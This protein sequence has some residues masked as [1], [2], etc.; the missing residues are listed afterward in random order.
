MKISFHRSWKTVKEGNKIK[1]IPTKDETFVIITICWNQIRTR[2]STTLLISENNWNEKKQRA[3]N[4][5]SSAFEFNLFLNKLETGIKQFYLSCRNQSIIPTKVMIDEEIKRLRSPEKFYH[6]KTDKTL[7]DYFQAYIQKRESLD[8]TNSDKIS[9]R[10]VKHFRTTLN[11][12][13]GFQDESQGV[14]GF[15]TLNKDFYDNFIRYLIEK[16]LNNSS[17]FGTIKKFKTF[18]NYCLENKLTKNDDYKKAFRQKREHNEKISQS[19]ALTEFE[20]SALEQV[21][22]E[23][24]SLKKVRDMFLIQ[25]MTLQRYSDLEELLPKLFKAIEFKKDR[26]EFYQQKTKNPA[27]VILSPWLC[28]ILSIYRETGLKII[29]NQKYNEYLKKCCEYAGFVDPVYITHFRGTEKK[30]TEYKKFKVVGSHTARRSGITIL[31][32]NRLLKEE[33]MRISGHSAASKSAFDD[34][35]KINDDEIVNKVC[36]IWK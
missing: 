1:S 29:S 13:K 21:S 28:R 25:T 33:I 6:K 27:L 2:L 11:H 36:E 26:V 15:D 30:D 34:Y 35:I 14:L 32:K 8:K 4:S 5:Y 12:L 20:L 22:L 9:E 17:A 18:L 24:E 23:S 31:Y 10:T 16:G 19:I 3:K 7:L